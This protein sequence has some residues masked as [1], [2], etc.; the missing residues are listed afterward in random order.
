[1][2]NLFIFAI[3]IGV[4]CASEM[5]SNKYDHIDVDQF[6]KNERIFKRAIECLLNDKGCTPEVNYLKCNYN[7]FYLNFLVKNQT[8]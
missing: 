5:Y 2:K 1:M 8:Q 4:T 7:L 3:I 6:I